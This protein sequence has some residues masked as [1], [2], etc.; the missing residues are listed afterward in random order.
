ML[1][2]GQTIVRNLTLAQAS[3]V[4]DGLVKA[5]YDFLF[6][7]LV[8][9]I[10]GTTLTTT[11]RRFIG[12]LDIFGFEDFPKNS[13]EQL[14]INLANETLQQHYNNYIFTKDIEVPAP[15]LQPVQPRAS[16]PPL[17]QSAPSA[18]CG[19]SAHPPSA[20]GNLLIND[21]PD[22]LA[23]QNER[24]SHFPA[25]RCHNSVLGHGGKRF[26]GAGKKT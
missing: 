13:F 11:S 6:G 14:C 22:P 20:L 9:R 2:R 4:R 25:F 8:E 7:W 5:L 15:A 17:F 10:N 18:A 12:L 16:P 1:I 3:D 26:P 19:R 21:P 23:G 24:E